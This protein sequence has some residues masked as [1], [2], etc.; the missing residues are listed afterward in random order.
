MKDKKYRDDKKSQKHYSAQEENSR[1]E[2]LQLNEALQHL[3]RKKD[4]SEKEWFTR[5]FFYSQVL[6][7]K[8]PSPKFQNHLVFIIFHNKI[9]VVLSFECGGLLSVKTYNKLKS[10]LQISSLHKR[11]RL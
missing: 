8:S 3:T 7:S 6:Y 1:E 11:F 9:F 10:S 5:S 2:V 4:R